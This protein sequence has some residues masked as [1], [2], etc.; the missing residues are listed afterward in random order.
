MQFLR[1][2]NNPQLRMT[3]AGTNSGVRAKDFSAERANYQGQII[4]D[5]WSQH[6]DKASFQNQLRLKAGTPCPG[7]ALGEW[8][9]VH[10]GFSHPGHDKEEGSRV[11]K[12][13]TWRGNRLASIM[14]N[15]QLHC[16]CFCLHQTDLMF[17][18]LYR[19]PG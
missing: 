17:L 13:K 11:L 9:C 14:L 3:G 12:S 8:D 19:S 7:P 5:P 4:P 6:R 18:T 10:P 2:A 1:A 16:F 15:N